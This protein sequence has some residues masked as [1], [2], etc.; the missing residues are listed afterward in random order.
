M[1]T[2]ATGQDKNRLQ[3][4]TPSPL[5]LPLSLLVLKGTCR[6]QEPVTCVR[7]PRA[8]VWINSACW[9]SMSGRSQ[10]TRVDSSW[11]VS[12]SSA[13]TKLTM[14]NVLQT[15][16]PKWGFAAHHTQCVSMIL[17]YTQMSLR[18]PHP[19]RCHSHCSIPGA[20]FVA[21]HSKVLPQATTK[22]ILLYVRM[23]FSH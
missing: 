7:C 9:W 2:Q 11:S 4:L 16:G 8:I 1:P 17:P 21:R 18:H 13:T 15:S 10:R 12:P 14:V 23:A 19:L 6:V 5:L 20:I 3:C 22:G